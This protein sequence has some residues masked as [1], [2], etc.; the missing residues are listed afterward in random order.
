MLSDIQVTYVM[1]R[2][3]S[4]RLPE[5]L[6]TRWAATLAAGDTGIALFVALI[7]FGGASNALAAAIVSTVFV[8]AA[9][10]ACGLYKKSYAVSARDEAFYA[11][12][13]M[14]VATIPIA[15]LVGG[16][17]QID[18]TA[19]A[20]ALIFSAL[21]TS[22]WH[23]GAHLQRREGPRLLACVPSVTPAA[24]HAR[25]SAGYLLAKRCFDVAVALVALVV[26]APIM[27][28]AA[29]AIVAET[30]KPVL[31]KQERVGRD[32]ARF[33]VLKFRTMR[34]DAG[35]D[36]ARPGDTRI[37][38]IGALLRRSSIDEL[39]Q[40]FNVLRAEMSIVGPRPEMV[41][42]ADRFRREL[43]AYDQRH[44]V[45]PGITG[46]AQV[47]LQRNLTPSDIK[48]VLPYDLFYVESASLVLD[49]AIVLKTL[50]E[51]L[52]HR[53]V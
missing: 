34:T 31:F 32:G 46:W 22:A 11:C 27:I 4:G 40:L 38:K 48:D 17:G 14:S 53:A 49:T 52:R 9:F 10:W 33:E 24:W 37:T 47:Y 35:A 7:V 16:V 28:A 15:L 25:E 42:F 19:I 8:T 5:R 45:T 39:P 6:S 50:L 51:V 21:A 23:A 26:T 20:G 30:G 13:A 44:I 43:P 2:A 12:T 29:L 36:W 41:E 3:R 18:A 1:P